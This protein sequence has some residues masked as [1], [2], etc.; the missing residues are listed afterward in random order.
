[1]KSL[2]VRQQSNLHTIGSPI[3]HRAF[4]LE[5]LNIR[6]ARPFDALSHSDNHVS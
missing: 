2:S 4:S 1:M 6:P 3:C 5:I